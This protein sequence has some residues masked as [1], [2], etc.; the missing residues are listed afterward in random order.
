MALGPTEAEAFGIEYLDGVI[1]RFAEE[2][3]QS[4]CT[5]FFRLGGVVPIRGES[6]EFDGQDAAR[7]LAPFTG[8]DSNS[9]RVALDARN[10]KRITP[11]DIKLS[12]F[13]PGSRLYRQRALGGL[14]ADA[15]KVVSAEAKS[16]M[17]QIQKSLEFVATGLLQG[18][19]TISP[20]TV[21]GSQ[22]TATLGEAATT[23]YNYATAGNPWSQAATK[24]LSEELPALEGAFIAGAGLAPGLALIGREVDGYLTGN[25]QVALW[26]KAQR[27]DA[28]LLA[29][30]ADFEV[31]GGL[32]LG[33]LEW[34]K[35]PGGYMSAGG[36]FTRYMPSDKVIVLPRNLNDVLGIVEGYGL[37]PA[38]AYGTL[39]Q[40]SGMAVEAPS[41]GFYAYVTD[42]GEEG[43]GVRVNV[44][45]RGTP[46][47]R[48]RSAVMV[49]TVV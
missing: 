2:I 11:F 8:P 20:A 22:I 43:I 6:F 48:Q 41:P 30:P 9:I 49:A 12:K 38:K 28:A 46:F 35:N 3:G 47:V 44:G 29:K 5:D 21:A 32:A 36:T 14:D 13:V 34:R 15:G 16:L 39:E 19:V 23:T 17:G 26:A 10:K 25:D 37:I 31:M 42:G 18:Q 24:I 1:Q 27:G 7:T 4:F 45:Y 33:G 40:A